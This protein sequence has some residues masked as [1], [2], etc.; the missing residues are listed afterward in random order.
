MNERIV[1]TYCEDGYCERRV[2]RR[3][4]RDGRN[5]GEGEWRRYFDH[6]D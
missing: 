5:R 1:D 2:F 6:D 4:Y 3:T